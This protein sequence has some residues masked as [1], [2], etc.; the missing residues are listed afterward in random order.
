MILKTLKIH[1]LILYI[2]TLR[3]TH[4]DS[5]GDLHSC[6][7]IRSAPPAPLIRVK[8]VPVVLF[9]AAQ[10]RV[11]VGVQRG[12]RQ[13]AAIRGVAHPGHPDTYAQ[14]V[15]VALR[16]AVH[17][18]ALHLGHPS[19]ARATGSTDATACGRR[20]P[21][22]KVRQATERSDAREGVDGSRLGQQLG[23]RREGGRCRTHS[24]LLLLAGRGRGARCVC[25]GHGWG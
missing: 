13:C 10:E 2:L 11:S 3:S 8:L 22:Q 18:G 24:L 19:T 15:S 1:I 7:A 25:V 9:V 4:R 12:P 16:H 20:Q 17:S 14:P 6:P 21:A 23:E 5:S